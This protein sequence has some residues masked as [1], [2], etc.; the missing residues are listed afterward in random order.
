MSRPASI[1]LC[2]TAAPRPLPTSSELAGGHDPL[3]FEILRDRCAYGRAI[4]DARGIPHAGA[5][6]EPGKA[7]DLNHHANLR[8]NLRR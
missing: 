8:A 7:L 6:Q 5:A 2:R 3:Q 4:V 1:R